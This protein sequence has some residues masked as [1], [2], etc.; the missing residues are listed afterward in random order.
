MG[1]LENAEARRRQH[2]DPARLDHRRSM[3]FTAK[4]R[5]LRGNDDTISKDR[6]ESFHNASE[7]ERKGAQVFVRSRPASTTALPVWKF[8]KD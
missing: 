8:V 2:Y 4:N 3:I 1:W 5:W 7:Y 6:V